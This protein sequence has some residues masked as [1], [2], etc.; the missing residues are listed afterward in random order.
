MIDG[1]ARRPIACSGKRAPLLYRWRTRPSDALQFCG[2]GVAL[3]DTRAASLALRLVSR[4][5]A[6]RGHL[7]YHTPR[8]GA[9]L[10]SRWPSESSC[11]A[12]ALADARSSAMAAPGATA[13]L[14]AV[15]HV[16]HQ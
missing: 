4:G 8:V 10:V 6:L 2:R 7:A 15:P 9:H 14:L 16:L 1:R 5:P 3:C 13:T 11:S 12:A